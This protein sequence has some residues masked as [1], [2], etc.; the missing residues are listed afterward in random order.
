MLSVN[1]NDMP[2]GDLG[3]N[4]AF[5]IGQAISG[6]AGRE[7]ARVLFDV[8]SGQT[9]GATT[10]VGFGDVPVARYVA[11][12]N[13]ATLYPTFA[14]GLLTLEQVPTTASALLLTNGQI[15]VSVSGVPGRDYVIEGTQDLG[16]ANWMPLATNQTSLAGWLQ[17][18]DAPAPGSQQRFYR[19]R[20]LPWSNP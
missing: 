2:D 13:G 7:L 8:D 18:S 19:A 15:Q 9:N 4:I 16:S 6:G 3:L 1:T 12:T 14:A 10:F 11:A 17:F 5:P 20:L